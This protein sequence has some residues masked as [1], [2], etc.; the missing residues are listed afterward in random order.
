MSGTRPF[1]VPHWGAR[2]PRPVPAWWALRTAWWALRA[3]CTPQN[4]VFA[5]ALILGWAM[6]LG[7]SGPTGWQARLCG[8]DAPA[9][10]CDG[11]Q[12]TATGRS[13]S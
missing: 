5:A 2:Q 4:L 9:L 3:A 10:A 13:A 7:W 6:L 12:G 8:A 1:V 11:V